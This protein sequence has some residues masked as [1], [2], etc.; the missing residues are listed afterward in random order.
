V[1]SLSL[2]ALGGLC[3]SASAMA[4]QAPVTITGHGADPLA[5]TAIQQGDLARAEALL[6]DRRLD[7]GDPVR[8]IN[9]G[10]VYWLSGRQG[11][12]ISAWQRA[13]ASRDH[14]DVQTVGGRL[15]S[16]YDIAR[17]ALATHGQPMR[18]A[19]R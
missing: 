18:T 2:I 17:E 15:L 13:L 7:A 8:L 14:Y 6:T 4:A 1:K 19:S 9:L 5:V 11:D 3:L 10:D 16:T 12:A